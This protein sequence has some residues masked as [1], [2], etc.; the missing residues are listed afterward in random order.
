M[1]SYLQGLFD[2]ALVALI[3][4]LAIGCA[5]IPGLFLRKAGHG[6]IVATAAT[7]LAAMAGV[8]AS[9]MLL[10]SHT[11]TTYTLDWS[12]PFGPC[13]LVIDPLSA[14][15]LLPV[16]LVSAA[17]SLFAV[18][19]WPAA[20]HR[21]TERGLTF[22][23][24]LLA[25]SMAILLT[26][27]NGVFFIMVWEVMA[28]SAYFLLVTE[29]EREEVRR[30]G[31]VYL[32]AT[33]TGTAAL[34]VYFSLLAAATGSFMLPA[35]GSLS[36]LPPAAATIALAAFIGFGAK[37]GIMPLHVWLPSAHANAPSHVS[38]LMS[39]VM[40]KM[41]LYGIFRTAT[42][43]YDPPLL[44]GTVL[45]VA[46][47]TSALLGIAFAVAQ[48]DLKRLL[49][50]SSIENI[51]II[52][53]G[54]GIALLGVSSHNV[55]LLYLGMAG[56]LLHILNHSFFKPLLFLGSGAVIHASGTR[57]MNLMGGLGKGMPRVALLFLTGSVAICGIPPLN[58]FVGEFLLYLGFFRQLT[59]GSMV[60][61]VFLAPLLALVG[62]LAVVA[63]TK[64]Y[65]SVFL[66]TPRTPA[67][68]HPHEAGVAMLAPMAFFAL[69]CLLVG[70]APQLALRL[71]T[72]AIEALYPQIGSTAVPAEYGAILGRLS[73]AGVL[74]LTAAV[75]VTLLWR[76][77]L[78]KAR[79]TSA[80]TWGC[81]Y[82]RGTPRVQYGG[83]SFSELA[84]SVFNG[85]MRQRVERPTLTGLFPGAARCSDVPTETLLER[86]IAPLFTLAGVSFSFL[87]RL[88]HGLMHVYMIYIFATLFILMLWAH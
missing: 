32:I 20:E 78:G 1:S 72:P 86:V 13:E 47:I 48:R 28:L 73:L 22:F 85:I 35:A 76:W 56:A 63:F 45:T 38:A 61:L 54:L 55:S 42:F 9:L 3:A 39:G 14:F 24:G 16:F 71:V 83:S 36:A 4:A 31:I 82:Q 75:V 51:G 37:A 17:G 79:V 70:V 52:T 44:W 50:C 29:H 7:I 74:L 8:P 40:L 26:A 80:S 11:T 67:A 64:L 41:G 66:G 6:Q 18:G 43:Y 58:G 81:G 12:L 77:R 19:Y 27:R 84:V 88:Q 59:A 21:A 23:Y 5:G 30:A 46:G 10:F 65:G 53:T 33:H 49:A 68:A 2:P 69:L 62:G 60:Y 25:S 15:F 57:E 87:R 34:F